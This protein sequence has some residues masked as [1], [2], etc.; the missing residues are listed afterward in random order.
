M[1]AMS[2]HPV[3]A[4]AQELLRGWLSHGLSH[5]S[6]QWVLSREQILA[7]AQNSLDYHLA[8]SAVP[9]HTGRDLWTIDLVERERADALIP[10]WQPWRDTADVLT[11]TYL[12]LLLPTLHQ[13]T[14]QQ[15]LQN[16]VSTAGSQELMAIC[17]AMPVLPYAEEVV[18][19][20]ATDALR[21]NVLDVFNAV[22]LHNPFP[23]L[24]FSDAAFN[25]MVLKAAFNGLNLSDIV[26]LDSRING[27]LVQMMQDY[28]AERQAAGRTV[29]EK[30]LSIAH[31]GAI[32]A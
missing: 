9:R 1:S 18:L 26:Q 20:L 17:R 28:V 13:D 27:A 19:P 29:S 3:S 5:E 8:F 11:R 32:N 14:Y 2:S 4:K 15:L 12:L 25:Q 6:W 23:A 10:G 16:M 30:W 24:H 7:Q 21:H 31:G 22:A